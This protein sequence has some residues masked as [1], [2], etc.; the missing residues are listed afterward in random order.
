VDRILRG[1]APGGLP[2][3]QAREFKL[4]FN[5]NTDKALALTIPPTLLVA[6]TRSSSKDVRRVQPIATAHARL[7]HDAEISGAAA[8]WSGYRGTFAVDGTAASMRAYDA[9]CVNTPEGRS[10]R[11]IVFYRRCGLHFVLLAMKLGLE[12]QVVLRV[13]HARVF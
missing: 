2:I 7:C 10:R 9:G 4:I 13:P 11:E 1:D 12:K 5:L 6:M 3:G 8:S